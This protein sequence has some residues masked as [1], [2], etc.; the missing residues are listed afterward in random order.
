MDAI[1]LAATLRA[2]GV[3]EDV[4][5][6]TLVA[7]LGGTPTAATTATAA[8]TRERKVYADGT[9]SPDRAE[10]ER[11]PCSAQHPAVKYTATRLSDGAKVVV[12]VAAGKPCDR[13]LG[14]E[15][16]AAIHGASK[17][18]HEARYNATIDDTKK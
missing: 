18:G 2:A 1:A 9:V 12:E 15:D 11:F 17:G 8:P 7:A 13:T 16:R 4:I 6:Q 3:P 14:H 10:A 5:A